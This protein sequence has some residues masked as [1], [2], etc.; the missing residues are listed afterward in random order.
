MIMENVRKCHLCD[1]PT[2][3]KYCENETCEVYLRDEK[4]IIDEHL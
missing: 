4:Q 3:N 2:I 1:E